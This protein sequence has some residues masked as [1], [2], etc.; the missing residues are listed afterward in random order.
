MSTRKGKI[1][2]IDKVARGRIFL[3]KQAKELGMV[4]EIGGV[5]QAITYAAGKANLKP[6]TYDVRPFPQPRTLADFFGGGN[7]DTSAVPISPIQPK[8][9]IS[10]D[11]VLN[12]VDPKTRQLIQQQIQFVQLLQQRP[13]A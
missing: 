3:A 12:L 4:D 6:G 2:D 5:E 7:S 8:I 11:S 1:A 13:I 9:T 10:P